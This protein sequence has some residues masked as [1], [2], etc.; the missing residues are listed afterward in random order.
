MLFCPWLRNSPTSSNV[1][2]EVSSVLSV[3]M[4]LPLMLTFT[5]PIDMLNDVV[6]FDCE[7]L[8]GSV[9]EWVWGV[10]LAVNERLVEFVTLY[11]GGVKLIRIPLNWID[12]ESS[13]L[14]ETVILTGMVLFAVL[15]SFAGVGGLN[16]SCG[17][18]SWR[19]RKLVDT[20]RLTL[21]DVSLAMMVMF[22][23]PTGSLIV[24]MIV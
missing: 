24:V 23:W 1:F 13:R 3:P 17:A 19:R 21:P 6:R 4:M 7:A 16:T 12:A 14:L 22:H 9:M 15:V 10:V 2:G 8:S 18:M 20:V 11:R 5:D